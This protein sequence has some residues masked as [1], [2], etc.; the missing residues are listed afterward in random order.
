MSGAEYLIPSFKVREHTTAGA[1]IVLAYEDAEEVVM[2]E[3]GGFDPSTTTTGTL[4]YIGADDVSV[5]LHVYTGWKKAIRG[6][7]SIEDSTTS[8]M[9]LQLT[10]AG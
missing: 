9:Y 8:G 7:K 10:Y 2:L 5:T 6:I 3:V 4:T 1:Q